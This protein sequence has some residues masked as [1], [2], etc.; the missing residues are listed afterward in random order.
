[1]PRADV[2]P[3]TV[4]P[5][6]VT[7]LTDAV[8]VRELVTVLRALE[9]TGAT[10]L[11]FKGAALAHTHY[12]QSWR[13]PRLDADI[14]IA[15]D[16]RPRVFTVLAGLGYERPLLISGDLVMYQAPFGRID[17]LGVEHALD[18]HW[19][20]VNPQVVSRAVTHAELVERSQMV[21]VDDHPMR[22]PSPVDALLIACLHRV[23]HPDFE[24]PCWIEDIHLLASRLEPS[25]W[26]AFTTRAA[27]RSIRAICLQGL[28]RAGELFQTAL[29]LDVITTLSEG[30]SEVSAVFLRKDLRPVDRLTVDL[31]AL[32]PRGAARLMREH[33]FP[34]ASYMRAKYGISSRAWLP[35]YYASRV[36]GG[37]W[38]WF[39]AA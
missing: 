24:Q 27:N 12:A 16:S 22:V 8:R 37:M 11:V 25:E 19:R 1:V 35:A 31:R 30:S 2:T 10:P 4:T 20:I 14:L 21:L 38:K 3:A 28:Q 33:M 26:Q 34:P 39:R 9:D 23:H 6:P 7:V 29:P 17:H 32:G 36:L 13:R 15:P 5:D 18:I